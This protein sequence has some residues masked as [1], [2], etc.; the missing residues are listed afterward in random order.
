MIE[1]TRHRVIDLAPK[2]GKG[3]LG[4]RARCVLRR[5]AGFHETDYLSDR[6]GFGGPCEQVAS[7]RAAPGFD[8]TALL[9]GSKYQLEKLL[10]DFLAACDVADFDRFARVLLREIEQGL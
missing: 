1:N 10:R 2:P 9:E 3:I 5:A 7:F 4:I 8:K 6:D